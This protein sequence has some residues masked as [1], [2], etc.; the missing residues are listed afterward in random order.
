MIFAPVMFILSL[1]TYF[2]REEVFRTWIRF[3]YWWVPLSFVVVLFAGSR[4]S[5]NIVGLSDQEIFGFLTWSLYVLI[6][7]VTIIWKYFG[8]RK[9]A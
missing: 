1:I 4:P 8:T 6:S 9:R 7:L 5:A 2:L 3:T